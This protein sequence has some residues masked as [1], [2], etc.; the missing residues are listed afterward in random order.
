MIGKQSYIVATINGFLMGSGSGTAGRVVAL[1]SR[2]PRFEARHHQSI[3]C[4]YIRRLH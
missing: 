1:D 4:E 2:H 3:L